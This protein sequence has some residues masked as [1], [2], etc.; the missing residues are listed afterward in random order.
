[1][2]LWWVSHN[3]LIIVWSQRQLTIDHL[4]MVVLVRRS[5]PDVDVMSAVILPLR[6]AC[7]ACILKSKILSCVWVPNDLA[8]I[9]FSRS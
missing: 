7:S 4:L 2:I 8:F 3:W 6:R 1:M 9:E 5:K